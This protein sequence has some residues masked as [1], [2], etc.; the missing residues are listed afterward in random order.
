MTLARG[1]LIVGLSL[2]PTS[3]QGM[4]YHI[5]LVTTQLNGAHYAATD[6]YG[7]HS[8]LRR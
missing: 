5:S 6:P 7:K 1:V 2:R 8:V 3:N 4:M